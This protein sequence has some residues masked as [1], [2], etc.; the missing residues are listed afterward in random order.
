MWGGFQAR[1]VRRTL[2][3][4]CPLNCGKPFL[5]RGAPPSRPC[6]RNFG[7]QWLAWQH[8]QHDLSYKHT[9]TLLKARRP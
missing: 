8:K 9:R 7:M 3:S 2:L 1:R 6:T 4:T 5:T